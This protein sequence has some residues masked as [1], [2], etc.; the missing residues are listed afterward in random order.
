MKSDYPQG[1]ILNC[2]P[3]KKGN[4][5][6]LSAVLSGALSLYSHVETIRVQELTISACDECDKH[7]LRTGQCVTKDDME[8]IYRH[9][10]KDDFIAVVTP[11]HFAGIPGYAKIMIDRCQKY[12]AQKRLL[13]RSPVSRKRGFVAMIGGMAPGQ[14]FEGAR[15]TLDRFMQTIQSRP[16]PEHVLI[17]PHVDA[18]GEVRKHGNDIRPFVDSLVETVTGLL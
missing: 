2:S 17:L 16:D 10:E 6:I 14:G 7:C 11:V 3:R 12:W 5:E 13:G 1:I 8:S 4:S 15:L 18:R 9:I